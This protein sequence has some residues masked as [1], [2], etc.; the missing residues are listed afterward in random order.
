MPQREHLFLRK[1][2]PYVDQELSVLWTSA[3]HPVVVHPLA[4]HPAPKHQHHLI[5]NGFKKMLQ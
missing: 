4:K 1:V 3:A 5:K 2:V